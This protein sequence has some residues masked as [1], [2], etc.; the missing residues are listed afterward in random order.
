VSARR[1]TKALRYALVRCE[2]RGGAIQRDDLAERGLDV[3]AEALDALAAAGLVD[4]RRWGWQ[5]TD[6]GRAAATA[7]ADEFRAVAS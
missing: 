2:R 7:Y 1:P 4:A 3:R 5:I 6:A